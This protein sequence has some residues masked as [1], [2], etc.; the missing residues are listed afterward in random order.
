MTNISGMVIKL[1]GVTDISGMVIEITG[2][3]DISG[4]VD[5]NNRG[6]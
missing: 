5:T 2:V 4:D 6:N 1:T 3:T